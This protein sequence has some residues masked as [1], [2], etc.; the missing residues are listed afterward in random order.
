MAGLIHQLDQLPRQKHLL[1]QHLRVAHAARDDH[2]A[3]DDRVHHIGHLARI[4]RLTRRMD[5]GDTVEERA[6]PVTPG[7]HR[8][9]VGGLYLGIEQ[10]VL[11]GGAGEDATGIT[12]G[13]LDITLGHQPH[14]DQD[15]L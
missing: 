12:A 11:I 3:F 5:L 10:P 6:E 13:D 4:D 15:L 9:A 1:H 8:T 7:Q 2:T 14:D